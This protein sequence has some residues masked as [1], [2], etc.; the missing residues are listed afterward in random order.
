MCHFEI[1]FGSPPG[2][3]CPPPWSVGLVL[4]RAGRSPR[5]RAGGTSGAAAGRQFWARPG[6]R[7]VL[8]RAVSS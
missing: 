1:E 4:A 2:L 5:Q 7:G 3:P 8:V 6:V